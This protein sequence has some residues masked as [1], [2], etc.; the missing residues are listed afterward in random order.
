MGIELVLAAP[1]GIYGVRGGSN[2]AIYRRWLPDT[3]YDD[4]IA[5][6]MIYVRF[7]QMKCTRKLCNN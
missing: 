2:G 7:L 6:S 5:M 1:M 3:D 4:V